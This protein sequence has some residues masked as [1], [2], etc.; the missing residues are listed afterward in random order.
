MQG[1]TSLFPFKQF[2]A[3]SFENHVD[4]N[5]RNEGEKS[6]KGFEIKAGKQRSILKLLEEMAKTQLTCS[7]CH[8]SMTHTNDF[9]D[10]KK[11]VTD[12]F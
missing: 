12:K 2:G 5:F 1:D 10:I 4:K 3:F 8:F 6:T 7:M 11:K 9:S